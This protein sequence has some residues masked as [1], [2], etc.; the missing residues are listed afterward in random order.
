[1]K[2]TWIVAVIEAGFAAY[3]LVQIV[4][5]VDGV[6]LLE[7]FVYALGDRLHRN[8]ARA[9]GLRLIGRPGC[10]AIGRE[11][12]NRRPVSAAKRPRRGRGRP[13]TRR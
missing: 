7:A 6:R 4:F 8:A 13:A 1:M 2:G 3:L 12:R 5:G 11:A 10:G 9:R